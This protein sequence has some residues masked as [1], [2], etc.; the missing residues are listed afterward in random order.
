[1][2][3]VLHVFG[4]MDRGGAETMIMNVYR[5]IDKNKIQFDFLCMSS[6]IG[7]YDEEIKK[8]GGK[9]F[10]ISP[11]AEINY[12]KHIY[13]IVRVCRKNGPYQAIHIP[14]MFHSGIACLAAWLA[15]V[16]T[17]IVHSHSAS[18]LNAGIKR[19]TY[20][21]ISRKLINLF[22][23]D[24]IACGQK[25][26][27]FLFGTSKKTKKEVIILN[28]CINVD[29]YTHVNQKEVDRLRESLNIK[30]ND[31]VIGNVANFS[32]AKNHQFLLKIAKKYFE[33]NKNVKFLLVGDGIL[34]TEIEKKIK[35]DDLGNYVILLGKREDIHVIM[36]MI[37]IFVMPSLHEGFPMTIIEALAAGKKCILSDTISEEVEV[38][39]DSVKF[40]SLQDDINVW[41]KTIQENCVQ[42]LDKNKVKD[43]LFEKGFDITT[44][45][46]ILEKIYLSK[47]N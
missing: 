47:V 14:T 4:V 27:D 24:K 20:N 16:P 17:R 44:T 46:N 40:L 23:T 21:F 15:K 41:V 10:R 34:K 35:Q 33:I 38:V 12:F 42:K 45:T 1:M 11:P 6:K 25:A 30:D 7:D 8:M 26:S 37:D 43:I 39:P 31:I 18:E 22:S 32:K 2:I 19:K 9:I 13:D 5:N 29:K 28:N 3:R 36:N